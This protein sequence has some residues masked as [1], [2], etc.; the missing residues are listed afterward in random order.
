MRLTDLIPR[1]SN[2]NQGLS[3]A[4]QTTMLA[5]LGSPRDTLSD[6]CQQPTNRTL[7]DLL[8]RG[9]LGIFRVFGLKHAVADLEQIFQAIKQEQREVFDSLGYSGM[10]CTRLVRGSTSSISNHAWGT[11]ID[12]NLDGR[13]DVVGDNQVQRGLALIAPI[14][15]R[16]GWYWGAGFGREDA[17][18]FEVSDERMRQWHAEGVLTGRAPHLPDDFLS[19]GDRGA[20]VVALQQRLQALGFTLQADG[21]FGPITRAALVSFQTSQ[22]LRPSGSLDADTAAALAE[23]GAVEET[24]DRS[25]ILLLGSRGAAVTQWQEFLEQQ[26]LLGPGS[27]DG[28]FGPTTRNA[29]AAFQG[30]QG[31]V[32][33]GVV[34]PKTRAEAEAV[35]L[36]RAAPPEVRSGSLRRMKNSELTADIIQQAP[37]LLREHYPKPIG[38]Q[39]PFMSDAKPLVGVLEWHFDERRGKHKGFSVFVPIA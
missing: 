14:F 6:E 35:G 28:E 2:I 25:A 11:A 16:H 31:L 1:P 10:L 13:L 8:A 37:R 32:P 17:M 4:R 18:H 29:T 22:A 5:L 39:I 33:D 3:P 12:L 34:G 30:Q 19:Q 38:T 36:G 24:G 27:V 15:N 9:D 23:A 20:E 21:S 7:I 26:G